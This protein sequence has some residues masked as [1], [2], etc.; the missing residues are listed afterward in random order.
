MNNSQIAVIVLAAGKGTRMKS[1]I[2]KVLHEIGGKPMIQHT[3]DTLSKMN[4][5]QIIVVV[6]YGAAQVKDALGPSFIDTLQ[7]NFTGG[8]GDAVKTGLTKLDPKS[9]VVLILGGDD[10]AFYK[11]ETLEEFLEFHFENKNTISVIT[12]DKSDS[13]RFGRMIRNSNGEFEKTMEAWEYE[14]SGLHIEEVN[15]GAYVFDSNWLKENIG[16]LDNNNDKQEY[17]ITELLNLAHDQ[18]E[19]VGLFKL[20]DPNEWIGVNTPEDLA[21]ANELVGKL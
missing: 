6:G 7:E 19:K 12:I 3:L 8:T 10:S 1:E 21:K 15:C 2:P 20:K 11:K 17:R 9:E 4:F 14:K 16:N 18:G 13:E 5:G